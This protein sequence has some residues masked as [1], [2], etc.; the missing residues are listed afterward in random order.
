MLEMTRLEVAAGEANPP[1][2]PVWGWSQRM[3]LLGATLLA[4][5]IIVGLF[6][7]WNRPIAPI[8]AID[9]EAIQ[10]DAAKLT[11]L[12][13]WHYWGLM[14]QGLDRRTDQL[15]AARRTA[16]HIWQTVAAVT[17]LFGIAL[18]GTGTAIG[19]KKRGGDGE[20]GRRGETPAT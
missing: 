5:A 6:L 17:A 7:Y 11:P 12:Q 10:R 4:S 2:L 8:D 19:R 14:K 1:S 3:I 20:K 16:Y 9:P 13:T 18:I 15:Y